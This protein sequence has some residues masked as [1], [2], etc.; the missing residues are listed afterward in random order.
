MSQVDCVTLLLMLYFKNKESDAIKYVIMIGNSNI[1]S[2][3]A[4]NVADSFEV[5]NVSA[6]EV[7]V[8]A[9]NLKNLVEELAANTN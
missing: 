8:E 2:D 6:E 5:I 9:N 3:A 7:F 4:H 1:Q